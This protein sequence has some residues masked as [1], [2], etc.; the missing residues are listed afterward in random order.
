MYCA[1]GYSLSAKKLV[2]EHPSLANVLAVQRVLT[3]LV[4]EAFRP[5]D[6]GC[7]CGTLDLNVTVRQ[8]LLSKC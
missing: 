2:L 8:R 7:G 3:R 1:P 4:E 5:F 6:F